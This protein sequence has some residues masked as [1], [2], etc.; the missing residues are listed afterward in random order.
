M[1]VLDTIIFIYK[2]LSTVQQIILPILQKGALV[3]RPVIGI[4]CDYD[5]NA[6]RSAL[7]DTYEKAIYHAGGL[8]VLLSISAVHVPEET[9]YHL[10]GLLLSGGGDVNP[11]LYGEMPKPK[12]GSVNPERDEQEIALCKAMET[13]KKPILGICRGAQVLNVAMGGTVYQDIFSEIA[14]QNLMKHSQEA[15]RR[16]PSHMVEL[17]QGSLLETVF[18]KRQLLVNSFHHQ[19]VKDAA[20][21]FSITAYA[22]DGLPEA[23]EK[24]TDAIAVGVQW[25]PE[26]MFDTDEDSQKLFGWFVSTCQIKKR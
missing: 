20:P 10:D 16:M 15:P 4:T 11:L 23:I 18:G 21:N 12:L 19:A 9:A 7:S 2:N 26:C 14:F 5:S 6:G 13:E 8:P 1:M 17:K 25:H 3:M 22:N 24:I